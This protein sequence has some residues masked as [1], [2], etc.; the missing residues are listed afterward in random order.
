MEITKDQLKLILQKAPEGSDPKKVVKALQAKGHTI[1]GLTSQ[2]QFKTQSPLVA[3]VAEKI[4]KAGVTIPAKSAA[5]SSTTSQATP[6]MPSKSREDVLATA[7]ESLKA[8]GIKEGTPEY[9]QALAS[10]EKSAAATVP[11]YQTTQLTQGEAPPEP[12][13]FENIKQ[14]FEGAIEKRTDTIDEAR[15]L[16]QAG[17]I[18]EEEFNKIATRG[19]LGSVVSAPAAAVRES[20]SPITDP[21]VEKVLAPYLKESV[22]PALDLVVSAMQGTT[23]PI[24]PL[25]N[26]LVGQDNAI[27]QGLDDLEQKYKTDPAF[28]VKADSLLQ[29]GGSGLDL[30]DLIATAQ[31]GKSLV[32]KAIETAPSAAAKTVELGGKAKQMLSEVAQSLKTKL[33]TSKN[34]QQEIMQALDKRTIEIFE[35]EQLAKEFGVTLPASSF[36]TPIKSKAEQIIGEGLFGGEIKNTAVKAIDDFSESLTKIQKQAPTSGELGEDI[37]KQF[38]I[39]EKQR[40]TAIKELYDQVEDMIKNGRTVYVDSGKTSAFLDGLIKR[41]QLS[42]V[43]SPAEVDF[44]K[45]IKSGLGNVNVDVNRA[46][47]MDIGDKA[48]FSSFDPTTDEKL[49][50]KLYYTLKNDIDASISKDLPELAPTL[51]EANDSFKAFEKLRQRPFAKSI[52]KLGGSGDVDTLAD[53]LTKTKASANEI[54][55]IYDTLGDKTTKN[56]QAKIIADIIEKAKSPTG[57]FTPA[58]F[59]KQLNAIGDEKLSILLT[60]EQIQLVKN[61]D[62]INQLIAKGT[63]VARGS[64]TA[65]LQ[66]FTNVLR[67]VTVLPSMGTSALGE[68]I[69]AR[70]FRS[71]KGQAFLKGVDKKTIDALKAAAQ[72]SS[73]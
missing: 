71:A 73:E 30:L 16:L 33:K 24:Q 59:A 55:Q 41:K 23:Q 19:M 44:L 13:Y 38:T 32:T 27:A 37:L 11:K 69:L 4:G 50:R 39:I 67:G 43:S 10:L 72:A 63:A 61:M 45:K 57:G 18:T 46:T 60:K 34:P 48:N 28:K 21:L 35:A 14:G 62:K 53:R 12:G 25:A 20:L 66:M 56:I 40:K 49:F 1:Q 7:V 8:Q 70:F 9:V 29:L 31:I 65:P 2:E 47:L 58:G 5:P 54:K 52:K 22:G 42:A 51:K 3:S 17:Q 64:Q 6:Q 15:K 26:K 36:A 68:W